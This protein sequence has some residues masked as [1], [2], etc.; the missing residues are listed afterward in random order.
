MQTDVG[1]ITE[2][3]PV[4]TASFSYE[5][6]YAYSHDVIQNDNVLRIFPRSGGSQTNVQYYVFVSPSDYH[7]A[8]TDRLGNTVRR[9]NIIQ[10]HRELEIR[11]NGTVDLA[12]QAL[13]VADL[14]LELYRRQAPVES[15]FLAET[16]LV[17]PSGLMG[18]A[19]EATGG[20]GLVLEAVDAVVQW[21]HGNIRYERGY[22]SV[23][24]KAE[25]VLA[26][27]FGV[28]Q[29]FAHVA[30]GMLRAIGVPARYVSGLMASQTGETHAWIEFY[31]LTEGWLP[32]DPT[33]KMVIPL[34]AD[35]LTFA[36]GRDYSDVP[37]V[38]GSFLSSGE[39]VFMAVNTS[40]SIL[41]KDVPD[42]RDAERGVMT[43]DPRALSQDVSLWLTNSRVYNLIWLGRWMER[44]ESLIRAIDSAALTYLGDQGPDVVPTQALRSVALAWG[45]EP[46]DPEDPLS[47]LINQ[48]GA[49]S[50]RVSV[51]RARDN[52][53]QVAPLELMTALNV[54]LLRLDN[55]E[56]GPLSPSAL[57]DFAT[58]ILNE[59]AESSRIVEEV[60]FKREGLTEEEIV[61]RF[62]Q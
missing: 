59:M 18:A 36:V 6:F 26:A 53:H 2:I 35:L 7:V 20:A 43:T 13:F 23:G 14:P 38:S 3:A 39:A 51:E 46:N 29:D 45:I 37:P 42:A 48:A 60:W 28:C 16:A 33:R 34:P 58:Q 21:L 11:V 12:V 55:I 24:T 4:T 44:A 27:G 30:V 50:V 40:L 22:T 32:A 31:H 1:S 19:A 8:Y 47:A 62:L 52:A 5:A 61:R 54:L 56:A 49:S 17:S 10:V 25:D 57:H 9:S 41:E 15:E